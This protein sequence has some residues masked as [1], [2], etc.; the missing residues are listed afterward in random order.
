MSVIACSYSL[1]L[2]EHKRTCT[3]THALT[4][5]HRNTQRHPHPQRSHPDPG[6]VGVSNPSC[7]HTG[8]PAAAKQPTVAMFPLTTSK[9]A[10]RG[11]E[12]NI[13]SSIC[14][15]RHCSEKNLYI[16]KLECQAVRLHHMANVTVWHTRFS[17]KTRAQTGGSPI[18]SSVTLY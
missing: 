5:T 8:V 18:Q 13:I 12:Q 14:M 2:H 7:P 17:E 4:Q 3:H 6:P 1:E 16:F 10:P 9:I 15:T 11:S